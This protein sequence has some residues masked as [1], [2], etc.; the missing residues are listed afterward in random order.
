MTGVLIRR[1][2]T[3]MDTEREDGQAMTWAEARVLCL[4]PEECQGL[5]EAGRKPWSHP[6][7]LQRE[8]GTA[9]TFI[10]DFWF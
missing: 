9:N 5:L 3:Q 4:R 7:S 8:H 2:K 6:W 10:S 1:E